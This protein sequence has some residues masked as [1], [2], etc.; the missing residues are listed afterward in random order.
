MEA[1]PDRHVSLKENPRS[2][3]LDVTIFF[4]RKRERKTKD[5]RATETF[6]P[7]SSRSKKTTMLLTGTETPKAK[8]KSTPRKS[9]HLTRQTRVK[10]PKAKTIILETDRKKK[11]ATSQLRIVGTAV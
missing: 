10:K 9:Q 4:Q 8:A 2:Q 5:P 11:A 1:V 3:S 7:S 6:E